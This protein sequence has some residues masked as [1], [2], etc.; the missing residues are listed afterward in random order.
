MLLRHEYDGSSIGNHVIAGVNEYVPN[1]DGF[2]RGDLVDSSTGRAGGGRTG[3][4]RKAESSRLINIADRTFRDHTC[5]TLEP[6][7]LTEDATPAGCVD[8]GPLFDDDNVAWP[9]PIDGSRAKVSFWTRWRGARREFHGGDPASY[10][11]GCGERSDTGDRTRESELIKR[12]GN[13]ATVQADETC[14][15]GIQLRHC[16]KYIASDGQ[17]AVTAGELPVPGAAESPGI[18]IAL[19]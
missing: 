15:E 19:G 5:E 4:N 8:T 11:S 9:G 3:I 6:C 12:V 2:I 7:S 16:R 18:E 17:F 1:E 14:G 10:S 13:G